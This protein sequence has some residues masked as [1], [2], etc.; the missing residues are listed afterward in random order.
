MPCAPS[1][2]SSRNSRINAGICPLMRKT[3]L[4]SLVALLVLP[5]AGSAATVDADVQHRH[6][7]TFGV[8]AFKAA[9]GE[10]NDVTVTEPAGELRFHDDRNRV[11][12][13]GD[14]E[15]VNRNT[16]LCPLTEDNP[17]VKLGNRDDRATVV[18]LATALGGSGD[19]RLL[20]SAGFNSLDG[21]DGDDTLRG[22]GDGDDLTGGPGRDRLFG[23][24][25]DDDLID[26]ETDANAARDV[27]RGGSSRDT[28]GADRGDQIFYTKR[29]EAL[30]IDLLRGKNPLLPGNVM[31]GAE[32]DDIEGLESVAGG[33]G[34]DRL[35]GDGDDNLLEGNG[36][37]DYVNG[38]SG[39]DIV[40]GGRGTDRVT[41]DV[42]SDV[43]WGNAGDDSL[44]SGGR[45]PDLIISSDPNAEAV[46]C[47]SGSDTIRSTRLDTLG[48]DCEVATSNSL[49]VRVQ[50]QINGNDATFRVACQR[51]PGGCGGTLTLT[52]PDGEDYGSGTFT[53]LPNDPQTFTPVSVT[54]TPEGV[55]AI[56]RGVIVQVA[57]GD[58]RGYRAFMRSG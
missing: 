57:F 1:S 8:V 48:R 17:K 46:S 50:P 21:Q 4:L 11:K 27:Y 5:S 12:A 37:N 49:S 58:K 42:G 56:D 15:Q 18:G 52:G 53:G 43:V 3:S 30:N 44:L 16:V 32:G 35:V 33:S 51:R 6:G 45:Q 14:C 20:G 31:K 2:F 41:G 54:L 38:R 24:N 23:G 10:V 25:G 13:R 22:A 29:D 9:R 40:M 36:G 19:D 7:T 34:D 26:G 28:A 47:G 39:D 55:D